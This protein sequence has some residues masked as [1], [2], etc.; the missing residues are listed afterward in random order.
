MSS[1]ALRRRARPACALGGIRIESLEERRLP[2]GPGY[3]L[4]GTAWANP[5]A[6]SYSLVPDGT[7][8]DQGVSNL[9]S[10]L[11][12]QVGAGNWAPQI[13][14]ALATWES[15][16]NIN[17]FPVGDS[18]APF[19]SYG[20]AQ[21][22]PSFGDIRIAGYNF[23]NNGLLAQTYPPPPGGWT[24]GGD[25]ELN[26]AFTW[27]IGSGFDLFSV[28]LHEMGHALGLA[29]APNPEDVMYQQYQGV[30]SGLGP[31]DIAGI[32][33]LY[34]PRTP[35]AYQSAGQGVSFASA[36]PINAYLNSTGQG[37]VAGVEL[38]SIGD[39]EFFRLTAPNDPNLTLQA[40][41]AASGV[42]MLSPEIQVFDASGNLLSQ[43]AQ[44]GNWSDNVGATAPLTPGASYVIA[45]KGATNDVFSTG[46][47]Q[48]HINIQGMPQPPA[49]AP[50]A[51][52]P[53]TP[54]PPA[55]VI[56]PTPSSG[57]AQSEHHPF[58]HLIHRAAIH[59]RARFEHTRLRPAIA[60]KA[61]PLMHVA[62]N[63]AKSS[64]A[65]AFD[66]LVSVL[67]SR[68]HPRRK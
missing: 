55:P 34:G 50:P 53:Q 49:P 16:A 42:S 68:P 11:N 6:I 8:W 54:A 24:A 18:G 44:P 33:Y 14:K 7:V 57:S 30:R 3:V 12:S 48:L 4:E 31:G 47:Y 22:D 41:A 25:S 15:V 66:S 5:S 64:H 37:T 59:P 20:P 29:E 67:L 38:G 61:S 56:T 36:T 19:N 60:V 58:K 43:A 39:T 62:P 65:G 40:V 27:S 10:T 9:V 23:N 46:A 26:T 21:G 52:A 32:Q 2:T 1:R 45:V 51:P 63:A 13:A 28:E 35:D 17:I